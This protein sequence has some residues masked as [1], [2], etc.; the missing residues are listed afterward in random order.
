MSRKSPFR[1]KPAS[2]RKRSRLG[3]FIPYQLEF[4]EERPVEMTDFN[5]ADAMADS[6]ALG[7]QDRSRFM[8]P[9]NMSLAERR[10]QGY[11]PGPYRR[12]RKAKK[13][14][15]R[16]RA[17]G[18][19]VYKPTGTIAGVIGRGS[20]FTDAMGAMG[21][22]AKRLTPAG[23]FARIGQAGGGALG[24][25]WGASLGRLLGQGV[26]NVVGFGEYNVI[27]NSVMAQLDEGVQIPAFGNMSMATIV[28]HRSYVQ[29]IVTPATP[30]AFN[31]TSFRINPANSSLF[32]W[33]S[34]LANS[35]EQYQIIGCVLQYKSLSS[36]SASSLALGSITMA[37]KYEANEP[38][39]VSKA[40]MENSQY[41]VS[42]RPC[43]DLI[44]ILECDPS[45]MSD[46]I[47]YNLQSGIY[48]V[49]KDPRLYDVGSF[50]IATNGLPSSAGQ[51]LGE[52]WITYQVALYRPIL[53]TL[54]ATDHFT[55]A[56]G[57]VSTPNALFTT[58]SVGLAPDAG[59][60]LGCT[61]VGSNLIFPPGL[62]SGT[63]V[64]DALWAGALTAI[65]VNLA[66]TLTNC[67]TGGVHSHLEWPGATSVYQTGTYYVRITGA[68]AKMNFATGTP[69]LPSSLTAVNLT[70]TKIPD[71]F[72][73]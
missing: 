39:F 30:T 48:P 15:T 32:P 14:T 62:V 44:H 28:S 4:E 34:T 9:L 35:Y 42:G 37:T 57:S 33:L 12:R 21:R 49:G 31:V 18:F 47:K 61:V 26:S 50:Q 25:P 66:P 73:A 19:Q 60:T 72:Y 59:S 17:G 8:G 67:T 16:R 20:Y 53:N 11:A 7:P 41:C 40:E 45:V 58:S 36:D 69:T 56:A 64:V 6:A 10:A 1:F 63:Y 52:L 38:A 29:D 70:V 2:Q 22:A 65:A 13:K 71:A 24:G 23:A 68:G 51:V 27:A 55:L 54:A 3:E 43:S 46:P 5:M